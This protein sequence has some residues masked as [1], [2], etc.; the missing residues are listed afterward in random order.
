MAAA[1]VAPVPYATAASP[2]PL[3]PESVECEPGG[4]KVRLRVHGLTK[5][6]AYLVTGTRL[7]D[8]TGRPVVIPSGGF[9]VTAR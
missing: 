6:A 1:A 5:G 3:I 9:A 7:T 4:P 8:C 2:I